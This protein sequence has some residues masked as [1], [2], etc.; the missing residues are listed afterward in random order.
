MLCT[1]N[2]SQWSQLWLKKKK[3]DIH[4]D[5]MI[6]TIGK[7]SSFKRNIS[8]KEMVSDEKILHKI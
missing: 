8:K 4:N 6:I 7:N 5:E 2:G 1:E 3:L